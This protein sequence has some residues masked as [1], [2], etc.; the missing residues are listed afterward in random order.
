ML[1]LEL[2]V[3]DGPDVLVRVLTMLRRRRCDIAHVDYLASDRHH[4]GR[5]VISIEPPPAHAHCVEAWLENLVDV[6]DVSALVSA[7]RC[8]PRTRR[9]ARPHAPRR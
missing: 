7:T 8:S 5:M 4:P 9:G 2:D 1:T 6:V 3:H